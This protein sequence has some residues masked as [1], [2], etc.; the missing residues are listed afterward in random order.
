VEQ[1]DAAALNARSAE[2]WEVVSATDQG[3]VL[4]K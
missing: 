4:K 1:V 2:G 3:V